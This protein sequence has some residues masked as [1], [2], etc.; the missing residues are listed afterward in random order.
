MISRRTLLQRT[1]AA[2]ALTGLSSCTPTPTPRRLAQVGYIAGFR[3]PGFTDA[4][5][6]A[7]RGGLRD[8]GYVE[9]STLQ[10]ELRFGEGDAARY[11]AYARELA[12][13]PVDVF[14][15]SNTDALTA[16][17]RVTP[18]IP[19]VLASSS[20]PVEA[21]FGVES[22]SRP[23]GNVTG[24]GTQTAAVTTKRLE[25]L[26]E[27]F[28]NASRVATLW[29]GESH[30][31]PSVRAAEETA[32]A[33][34]MGHVLL[35]VRAASAAAD[36]RKALD[37]ATSSAADSLHVLRGNIHVIQL[38][39]DIIEY[40]ASRRLPAAYP[41]LGNYIEAGGLMAY[42]ANALDSFRRSASFIDRIL[43]GANPAEL[44]IEQPARFELVVNLTTAKEL[45]LT[46]PQSVLSRATKV[47]Q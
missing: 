3:E 18:K 19:I 5:I 25:V 24:M 4:L 20:D 8:L 42:D 15:T 14:V 27:A 11:D 34:Q 7:L 39:N 22:L 13:I 38:R 32:R 10:F 29:D 12:A 43:K 17:R 9:G 33:L 28:P 45:G 26:K 35:E 31:L 36:L 30:R 6:D 44:P 46:I 1:L 37:L 41:T 23:G 21:G 40:A 47:I 16:M 2:A